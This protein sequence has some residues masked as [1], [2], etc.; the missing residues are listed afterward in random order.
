MDKGV[1]TVGGSVVGGMASYAIIDAVNG[2][3]Q[4]QI[5]TGILS[6]ASNNESDSLLAVNFSGTESEL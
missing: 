6:S 5:Q 3:E 4:P 1:A 2:N